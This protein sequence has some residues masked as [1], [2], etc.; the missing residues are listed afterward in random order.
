MDAISGRAASDS[1]NLVQGSV[2]HR[3]C[4]GLPPK[5]LVVGRICYAPNTLFPLLIPSPSQPRVLAFSFESLPGLA[6][7]GL[8][9]SCFWRWPCWFLGWDI[10]TTGFAIGQHGFSLLQRW[11]SHATPQPPTLLITLQPKLLDPWHPLLHPNHIHTRTNPSSRLLLHT[12]SVSHSFCL[13]E[14]LAE[15]MQLYCFLNVNHGPP[16]MTY[17]VVCLCVCV[18]VCL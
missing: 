11:V 15:Y 7:S 9:P 17:C 13:A 6:L 16:V 10:F 2:E 8:F 3:G 14:H 5:S 18:C 12:A 4:A 1:S